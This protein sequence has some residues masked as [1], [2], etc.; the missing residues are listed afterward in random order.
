MAAM[1][2]QVARLIAASGRSYTK[3]QITL[4]KGGETK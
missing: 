1:G 3:R 2:R 4:N